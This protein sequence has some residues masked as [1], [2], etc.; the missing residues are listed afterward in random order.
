MFGLEK[1]PQVIIQYLQC[2][3]KKYA[4][5]AVHS[6]LKTTLYQHIINKCAYRQETYTVNAS[7]LHINFELITSVGKTVLCI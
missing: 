6:L 4:T 1:D 3:Y 5:Y 7:T 2:N